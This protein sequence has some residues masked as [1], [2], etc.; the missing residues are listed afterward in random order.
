MGI[1]INKNGNK[2][3]IKKVSGKKKDGRK[4]RKKRAQLHI[5][6]ESRFLKTFQTLVEGNLV[7]VL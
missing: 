3:K 7:E 2:R 1:G 5:S 6:K 4:E